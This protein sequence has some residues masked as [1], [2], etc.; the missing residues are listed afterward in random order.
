M[1]KIHTALSTIQD[2]FKKK[3][4]NTSNKKTYYPIYK[5]NNNKII[6]KEIPNMIYTATNQ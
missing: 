3:R 4:F 1:S 6:S 5:Q 2:L